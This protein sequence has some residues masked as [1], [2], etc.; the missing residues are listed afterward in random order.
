MKVL[1]LGVPNQEAAN[2]L[3]PSFL[4]SKADC[5]RIIVPDLDAPLSLAEYFREEGLG[6]YSVWLDYIDIVL[7][8]GDNPDSKYVSALREQCEIYETLFEVEGFARDKSIKN[9]KELC[10]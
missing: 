9:V 3:V 1:S 8:V 6:T 10:K 7:F 5:H 4:E 2:K